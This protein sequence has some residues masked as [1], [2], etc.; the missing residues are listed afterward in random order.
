MFLGPLGCV[1]KCIGFCLKVNL[2]NTLKKHMYVMFCF[3]IYFTRVFILLPLVILSHSFSYK[4]HTDAPLSWS[5]Y[6]AWSA[7]LSL[8]FL[9]I[10]G[11]TAGRIRGISLIPL[12]SDDLYL[13]P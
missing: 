8:S 4:G 6:Y 1:Q 13:D 9:A 2:A 12:Q 7:L 10:L 11:V 5:F 3:L